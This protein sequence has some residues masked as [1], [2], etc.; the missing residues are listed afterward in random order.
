MITKTFYLALDRTLATLR[1]MLL[2][3]IVAM[4]VAGGYFITAYPG[5]VK[6]NG[7][8]AT[9]EVGGEGVR[10]RIK[11]FRMT[12]KAA[13]GD[14]WNLTADTATIKDD[15][16]EMAEVQMHYFPAMKK[17]LGLNLSSHAA[18]VQNATSDV[19]FSGEVVVKTNGETPAIL[20]SE[21]LHWSQDK[22]QIFTGDAVRV[23]SRKAVITGHG[24]VVDVDRQTFTVLNAVQATF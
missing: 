11:L 10:G 22:R 24:L 19:A 5:P 12:E 21:T 7:W 23:E 2:A 17:G 8:G 18:V 9:S 14:R 3:G 13:G 20:H 15:V 1:F 16:K 6:A 4:I